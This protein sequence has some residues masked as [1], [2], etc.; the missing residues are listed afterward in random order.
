MRL[1]WNPSK[2]NPDVAAFK[3]HRVIVP[4][5]IPNLEGYYQDALEIL[6][7]CLESL[8]L[9]TKGKAGVTLISNNSIPEV[10]RRL[11]AYADEG[12]V[13]QLVINRKNWGRVDSMMAVAR[14][15]FEDCITFTDADVL[16]THGWL[17]ATEN[18]FRTFPECGFASTTPNPTFTYYC[19][20]ATI[21]GGLARRE[22][23]FEKIV[24]DE[25]LDR[26]AHSVGNED[27]FVP[28]HRESQ[29]IVRRNNVTACVGCGHFVCTI[30]KAV[31]AGIPKHPSLKKY[32]GKAS[33]GWMDSPP[34]KMGF[35]RLSTTRAYTYHLGNVT[36]PW[37]Y[38]KMAEMSSHEKENLMRV[39][40]ENAREDYL[41]TPRPTWAARVPWQ[42]RTSLVTKI[43]KVFFKAPSVASHKQTQTKRI[44]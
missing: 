5:Y 12:W 6:R 38:E 18:I 7:L 41:P 3:R 35:W 32:Q 39:E 26:F 30:R 22:L 2:F 23:S 44:A 1:G 42:W 34:D 37:M 20:S 24:P 25:D 8:R 11:Q 16:F 27:F 28:R 31:V 43:G 15:S 9:T 33:L 19:T 13:D 4:I 21:L 14:M 17:E 29:M 40:D 36:E 10:E